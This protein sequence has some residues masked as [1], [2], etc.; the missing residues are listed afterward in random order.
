MVQ[1]TAALIAFIL[2]GAVVAA[3]AASSIMPPKFENMLNEF[4]RVLETRKMTKN[5]IRLFSLFMKF[6]EEKINMEREESETSEEKT[7]FRGA[8]Y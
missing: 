3:S 4:E 7:V 2:V 5:D 1:K 8:R 6:I